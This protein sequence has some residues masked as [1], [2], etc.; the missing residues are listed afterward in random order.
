MDE[1]IGAQKMGC[2]SHRPS[3]RIRP[4]HTLTVSDK[5]T[6]RGGLCATSATFH[7]RLALV[8]CLWTAATASAFAA[9][10]PPQAAAP[11]L[12]A[13]VNVY[14]ANANVYA[15]SQGDG[16]IHPWHVAG[17]VWLMAGEPGSSNV[18]VQVGDEGLLMVD[19]GAQ[20][21][22][23][24]LLA[25]V[26][27]LAE[28]HSRDLKFVQL[29]INTN[30]RADHL[31]GNEIIRKSGQAIRA[32][33]EAA[34]G[35]PGGFEGAKV[36]ANQNVLNRLVEENSGSGATSPELWPNDTEDFD[37]YNFHS[38]GEALQIYHTHKSSTD[39]QLMVLFR[40][41]DVVAAGDVIDMTSYPLIDVARG[42]TIDGELV[43]LNKLIEITVPAE[44][45]EG[46][47]IVIPGHGRLCDQSEVVRYK[48]MVTIIRNRVQFYKNRGTSL[49]QVLSLKPSLD[50]DDRWGAGS[51][52]W[53]AR[54][55]ITAIYNT[56]PQKGSD[57]SMLNAT[58]VPAVPDVSTL[59]VPGIKLF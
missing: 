45:Q 17:D 35:S 59:K 43:A 1:I 6:L 49:Q 42:G 21:M 26:Q 33:N 36:L 2:V 37:I 51:G 31:G 54:E 55:F 50:Y 25:Q 40:R 11:V 18:V 4:T 47:T 32:G 15:P 7:V 10:T 53:N 9:E 29:I 57:F 5:P 3:A 20:S 34:S 48:N 28:E 23:P 22:A 12:G 58:L 46:G 52:Q 44:N 56:L 13:P 39:G 19:S 27:Q 14:A 41:S 30:G 38:N 24:K 8:A 16:E